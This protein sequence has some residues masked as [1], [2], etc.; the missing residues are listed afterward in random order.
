MSV[1][2]KRGTWLL[3]GTL[4][5]LGSGIPAFADDTELFVSNTSQFADTIRPNILFIIDTSGSM[6]T[7]V[8]TQATYD[9]ERFYDGDCRADRVYWR[10]RTGDPPGCGTRRW[11]SR[12]ALMCDV[13]IQAFASGAG[14]YTDRMSQY[15]DAGKDDRWEELHRAYKDRLVECEDDR[16]VHGDGSPG[17]SNVYASDDQP[18]ELWTA[19][20][21]NEIRWGQY[22]VSQV[23]TVYGGNY[24]NWYY[25][26]TSTSTRLQVV[27]DVAR[28]LLNS[29]NGVNV[30]LMRFNT[31]EGGPVVYAMADIATARAGMTD[32]INALPASGWTPLSETLYEAGQYFAGRNV[33][34]GD[35]Y[36]DQYGPT[37]SVADS[38]LSGNAAVYNSPIEYGC[39]K[40]FVVLLTD[41]EPTRDTGANA[42][43]PALPGFS[44]LVG[45]VCDGSG[46]ESCLDD[47]AHYLYEADLDPD[48]PGTQNVTTYTIGFTVDLPMLASTAARGGGRY[49]TAS[50]TASLSTALTN[51]VT[52]ILDS[53]TT[54]TAPAVAVNSFNRTRNLNDLYISVFRASGDVHWPGNL[55]K[56]RLRASDGEVV[57]AN[58][59]LA[60][61]P[62]TGYFIDTAQSYWSAD[63][64]GADTTAR[65]AANLI[66]DPVARDVYTYLGDPALSAAGNR[67][68]STN[69]L[70]DDALLG[71]GQ[72][73]DPTR[74]DLINF[75]LGL[76]VTDID[77]DTIVDEPRYQMGDPL[78]AKPVS[79]VYGGT[80]GS[81]DIDDAVIYFAT[82]DGY[83]HAID[84]AT[85]VE[86]WGFIPSELVG[87][88]V[89]LFNND[90]STAKHYGIDG[91]LTVQLL[92]KDNNGV[93]EPAAGEKVYLY[94][95]MRRGGTS[96]YGLDVT[97]PDTPK[98]MWTLD[99]ASLPGV[100]QSWSTPMPTRID[101]QGGA[102]NAEKLVLIFGGGY[103]ATH[104]NNDGSTDIKGNAIYIVD[105]ASG[106]LLW[107]ASDN[108]A[109]RNL[110]KMQ[111]SIPSD[112]RV[113]DLNADRYADRMYVA[114]MGGQVWQFDI[115]N[116]EPASNLINGGV[117]AELGGAPQDPSPATETR[118]FYYA[119]DVAPVND[120]NNNFVHVGI[121]SGHRAHPNSLLTQ[122]R[123]YALRDYTVF[124]T[125]TQTDYNTA[126]PTTDADLVDITDDVNAVV[127]IG[128]PGWRFELRDGGWRGEK[129]LAEARTFNDQ[130]FF[131]TFRPG[132]AASATDCQPRLGTNRL[133]V[134]DIFN[135]APVNNLDE[136]GGETLTESDRY[137]EFEGSIAS[138]VVFLF[139]S[140]DDPDTCVGDECTPP[141][142]AC[143]GLFCFPPGFVNNP[144]MTFWSEES[145]R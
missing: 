135:G 132:G 56:Y 93:I 21:I 22:L 43:I 64:D 80:V 69:L 62:D 115:F 42:K 72:V 44:G 81:P 96:Y 103:D 111:Y 2:N 138:E 99:G 102:Q 76:D 134:M 58:G 110:P 84:P 73:G 50:D 145:A 109:D 14:R 20:P 86:L 6:S 31:S 136:V 45:N 47:M 37:V 12:T 120:N 13:A 123:F 83:L 126:T 137:R 48:L 116:G 119:P 8:E 54:F 9:P 30:G 61:D 40:N 26:S 55:K 52:E 143:M 77:D 27:Q 28:N 91:N 5:A 108:G 112:V 33:D 65:G 23:V 98:L 106:V 60:V 127:P 38:R 10:T 104:D 101:I 35:P 41:G 29:V 121:G 7:E 39:Q 141:P 78:H 66:P 67:I 97:N 94:F 25:G 90:V 130:V 18:A 79:I 88:Q 140:P 51:I 53:N 15:D 3:A 139:P 133:Y 71:I 113:I 107:H 74:N 122:D 68:A 95:G 142:L 124:N 131:T 17:N 82:N 100:G 59:N 144:V 11:F 125:R 1:T 32:A 75:I 34:Y 85:G 24:M 57:D 114:D 92:L 105:S 36:G 89:E 128:S 87:D 129:V 63:V 118:R 4:W 117:I 46:S 49:H 19:D 16:G 70:I